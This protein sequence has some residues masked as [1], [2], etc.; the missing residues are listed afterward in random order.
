M[1]ILVSRWRFV[2]RCF[3]CSNSS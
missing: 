2:I 3:K 1:T